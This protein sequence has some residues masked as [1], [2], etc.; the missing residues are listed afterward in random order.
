MP[1]FQEIFNPNVQILLL[2][3][4]NDKNKPL[5]ETWFHHFFLAE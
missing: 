1:E 4:T 2:S 3:A 5:P